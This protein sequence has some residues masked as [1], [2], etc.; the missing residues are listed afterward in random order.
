M[1]RAI[2]MVASILVSI[3]AMIFIVERGIGY[4]Q[5]AKERA[6]KERIS[7]EVAKKIVDDRREKAERDK[8]C[9]EPY[10]VEFELLNDGTCRSRISGMYFSPPNTERGDNLK[11]IRAH[12]LGV[13]ANYDK[14][15]CC[16]QGRDGTC[17]AKAW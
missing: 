7:I 11:C 14:Q 9:T 15:K 13:Y 16:Q 6:E 8:V 4:Y 3:S 12:G 2:V 1:A 10:G 17:F 5:F